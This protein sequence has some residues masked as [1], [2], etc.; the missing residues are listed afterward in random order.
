MA[1]A[2]ISMKPNGE[3]QCTVPNCDRPHDAKG[4][5]RKHYAR[6]K[7]HGDPELAAREVGAPAQFMIEKVLMQPHGD[8]CV[9]WP[10]AKLGRGYGQIKINGQHVPAHRVVCAILNGPPSTPMH[11][12]AH[13]CGKGHLGCVNPRHLRWATPA[14]NSADRIEH[15]THMR[16]SEAPH[17]KLTEDQVREIRRAP[18]GTSLVELGRKFGVTPDAI[19]A[20]INRKSWAWLD[21]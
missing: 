14:E 4:Y 10:F 17:C 13:S 8:D 7:R 9:L 15:G 19:S 18:V 6:W 16:G 3:R 20:I 5:C 12:A 2:A 1:T 11:Q 21:A